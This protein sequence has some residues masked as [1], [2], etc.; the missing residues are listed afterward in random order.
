VWAVLGL[1]YLLALTPVILIVGRPLWAR[2]RLTF[3][4][5]AESGGN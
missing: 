3:T 1:V 4:E 2:R 5:A